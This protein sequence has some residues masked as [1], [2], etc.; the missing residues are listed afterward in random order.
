MLIYVIVAYDN[1]IVLCYYNTTIA[2]I[3]YNIIVHILKARLR[4]SYNIWRYDSCPNWR[5][6]YSTKPLGAYSGAL[7]AW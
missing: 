4:E 5:R 7:E 3:I 6:L 1:I 2:T